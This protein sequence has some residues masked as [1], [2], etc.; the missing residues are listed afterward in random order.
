[1]L[2]SRALPVDR[3][4]SFL[5]R[6]H[7]PAAAPPQPLRGLRRSVVRSTAG[8][9]VVRAFERA[10]SYHARA[11]LPSTAD[12]P[13]TS[14]DGTKQNSAHSHRPGRAHRRRRVCTARPPFVAPSTPRR[15]RGNPTRRNSTRSLCSPLA[16][17]PSHVLA[18]FQSHGLHELLDHDPCPARGIA[19]DRCAPPCAGVPSP[20]APDPPPTASLDSASLRCCLYHQP[21]GALD[22]FLPLQVDVALPRRVAVDSTRRATLDRRRSLACRRAARLAACDTHVL[23]LLRVSATTRSCGC[24]F[25]RSIVPRSQT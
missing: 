9:R 7:P 6:A 1:M 18:P 10:V 13:H 2:I 22:A 4:P 25:F 23:L 11:P 8:R 12:L 21:E 16:P 15:S 3:E 5:A 20:T 24:L 14:V 17:A 19:R